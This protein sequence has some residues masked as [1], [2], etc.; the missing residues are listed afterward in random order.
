MC[1]TLINSILTLRKSREV[2]LQPSHLGSFSAKI[3]NFRAGRAWHRNERW[4]QS[5]CCPD[6]EVPLELHQPDHGEPMQLLGTCESC[7]R[8]FFVVDLDSEWHRTLLLELPSAEMIRSEA[9]RLRRCHEARAIRQLRDY[10]VDL[11]SSPG[12]PGLTFFFRSH[13]RLTRFLTEL[14]GC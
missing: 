10:G 12:L 3:V 9:R 1:R 14:S 5:L 13:R 7:S 2:M 11:R 4:C 8:W 6:C